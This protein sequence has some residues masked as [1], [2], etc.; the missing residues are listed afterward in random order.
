MS[1]GEQSCLS[2]G[3]TQRLPTPAGRSSHRSGGQMTVTTLSSCFFSFLS[4]SLD[5]AA[6]PLMAARRK[7]SAVPLA[8]GHA[9]Q[10]L[11]P[12]RCAVLSAQALHETT[13]AP[14]KHMWATFGV[15]A[16]AVQAAGSG[17]QRAFRRGCLAALP[18]HSR[19]RGRRVAA[20]LYVGALASMRYAPSAR[21]GRRSGRLA[22][23][24]PPRATRLGSCAT[25]RMDG[26][27]DARARD[28]QPPQGARAEND[29][30]A[31][32]QPDARADALGP[33]DLGRVPRDG[34]MDGGRAA[35]RPAAVCAGLGVLPP[36]VLVELPDVAVPVLASNTRATRTC[37][38]HTCATCTHSST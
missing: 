20:R 15:V 8:H 35:A 23:A 1:V 14:S 13:P 12:S 3:P 16:C 33:R 37:V 26:W 28:V 24:W 21:V 27:M 25:R 17:E 22:S 10:C 2:Q 6:A 32:P 29:R 18:A 11:P 5:F 9:A 19:T 7:H 38:L 31:S 30:S 34:W 4:F 36:R